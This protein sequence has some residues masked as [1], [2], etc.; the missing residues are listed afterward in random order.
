MSTINHENKSVAVVTSSLLLVAALVL[1]SANLEVA[2][3]TYADA[4]KRGAERFHAAAA[5]AASMPAAKA[6]PM[7]L[8]G[9]QNAKTWAQHALSN[10]GTGSAEYCNNDFNF[11]YVRLALTWQP[12]Y[13]ASLTNNSCKQ[14]PRR[15]FRI[16]GLW[17]QR[18]DDVGPQFCCF[19]KELDRR[20][21]DPLI[22]KLNGN[23]VNLLQK[24][25]WQAALDALRHQW[26]KHGTCSRDLPGFRGQHSYISNSFNL[27]KSL[28]VT[29]TLR[30]NHIVP[31]PGAKY[32]GQL[33]MNTVR[34][35]VQGKRPQITC[36][37]DPHPEDPKDKAPLLTEIHF[38]Y[39]RSKQPID[40]PHTSFACLGQIKYFAPKP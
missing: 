30:Q 19:E 37:R 33:I 16:H 11:D 26:M 22:P 27:F 12:G 38:C 14:T 1:V 2:R 24:D 7:A 9:R 4:A 6:L 10:N 17:P 8:L 40:C 18:W 25:D 31:G 36:S 29:E 34:S 39:D 28:K 13:C 5:A 15:T 21:V 35:L 23:W 32:S 3:A 20:I